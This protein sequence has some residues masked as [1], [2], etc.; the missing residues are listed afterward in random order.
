MHHAS[1]KLTLS[2]AVPTRDAQSSQTASNTKKSR[3]KAQSGHGKGKAAVRHPKDI[4]EKFEDRH[5]A[6][7]PPCNS[8]WQ[9]ALK[10]VDRTRLAPAPK[11]CWEFWAPEPALFS[12]AAN[13]ERTHR[14][15]WAWMRCRPAWYW[16]LDNKVLASRGLKPPSL[17]DWKHYL[18]LGLHPEDAE[19]GDTPTAER[20]RVVVE[21]FHSVFDKE[22]LLDKEECWWG[23]RPFDGNEQQMREMIWELSDVGFRL[24]LVELDRALIP[25]PSDPI[26]RA[27]FEDERAKVLQQVFGTRPVLSRVYKFSVEGFSS[28][29]VSDRVGSLEGL[30]RVMVRWPNVPDTVS[31]L[32]P[33][34]TSTPLATVFTVERELCQFYCQRFWECAGRAATIPR[35]WPLTSSE[36]L[37]QPGTEV[38]RETRK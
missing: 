6:F 27:E 16:M 3:A 25:P 7:M 2:F 13:V 37:A 8:A 19:R 22:N 28:S 34:D 24:E 31:S 15:A 11:D 10:K 12:N 35:L 14:Y 1:I 9:D 29:T 18:N 32:P 21:Y 17:A 23:G 20:K 4:P 5:S 36:S 30:R 26:D 33:L 38:D